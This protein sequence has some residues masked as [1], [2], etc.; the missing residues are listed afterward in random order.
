M[1]CVKLEII[2]ALLKSSLTGVTGFSGKGILG[3]ITREKN[4]SVEILLTCC[5]ADWPQAIADFD[6]NAKVRQQSSAS[7]VAER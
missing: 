7:A 6:Q 1:C 5:P 3:A 2:F 4:Y